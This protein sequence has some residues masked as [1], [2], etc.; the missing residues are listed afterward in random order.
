MCSL[1]K[2]IVV[3]TENPLVHRAP[4]NQEGN[5]TEVSV[6]TTG[7]CDKFPEKQRYGSGSGDHCLQRQEEI[8]VGPSH[9]GFTISGFNL[10]LWIKIFEKKLQNSKKQNLDSL[11]AGKCK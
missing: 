4:Q 5:Y 10:Q 8:T 2:D 6:S 9:L 11:H 7:P 1:W 3:E